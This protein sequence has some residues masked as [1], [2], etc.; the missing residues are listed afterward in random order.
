LLVRVLSRQRRLRYLP[1]NRF[2]PTTVVVG[3]REFASYSKPTVIQ[4]TAE[5][6]ALLRPDMY[7]GSIVE[8][9]V[10]VWL[11]DNGHFTRR[12]ASFCP[13]LIK[14]VDEILV[15][16]ADNKQRD[17]R[18]AEIRVEIDKSTGE[19]SV[20]NDGRGLQIER[21][22]EG[23]DFIPFLVFGCLRTSTNYDDE[24]KRTVGGRNGFG[25]KLANIYSTRFHVKTASSENGLVFEQTWYNNMSK[26]DEPKITP[27]TGTAE[28]YTEVRFTPDYARLKTSLTPDT[29]ALLRRRVYDLAATLKGV[30]ISL[31]GEEITVDGLREYAQLCS[32]G[33]E[34]GDQRSTPIFYDAPS[35]RWE[36]AMRVR[37][38]LDDEDGRSQD[39]VSFVNNCATTK[40]GK[41]VDHVWDRCLAVLRP[42]VE[43]SL[44]RKVRP[45]QIKRRVSLFIN[46]LIDNPTF[47]TQ[48][49][50]TLSTTA[51]KFGSEYTVNERALRN[52]A[53]QV[54]LDELIKEDDTKK[55][56][57]TRRAS[58]S[59]LFVSKLE[60]A[61][62][63]GGKSSGECSLLLTEGD[64]AK[65]LA[66]S[67]LQVIGRD[68]FGVYPLRGKLKNVS[69]MDRRQAVEVPEVA[70]LM[71]ILGLVPNADYST[72][73]QRAKLRYGRIIL[74]TDQDE[75]GSHIKGL[76]MNIFRCLWPSLLRAPFITALETPLIKARM[77][78]STVSF[79]SRLEYDE[80]AERTEDSEK[81]KIKYYKG[82]GTSTAEEAREY[83][84]DLESRLVHYVWT[85][86]EDEESLEV[87]FGG[88]K[89]GERK[90]WIEAGERVDRKEDNPESRNVP[91]A[92]FVNGE[93]R[94]FAIQDLKR[95]I[96]S[97]VDG[98]KP[99]QR[100][101]L[102]TCL[103]MGQGKQEKVA[104]LAARVAQSTSYHHG[105]NSLIK[106]I[107][108]MAQD[109]VGASNLPLLRGIGQF[110]TR[111][112]GGED[113]ASARYIYA[114]LSPFSRRLFPSADDP[115]LTSVVEEGVVAEPVWFCPILP[116]V[117]INGTEGIATGWSTTVHP[118]DP[119][120]LVDTVRRRIEGDSR[121]EWAAEELLP[122]YSGF[123]GSIDRVD[124]RRIRC[125]GRIEV[126]KRAKAARFMKVLIDELPV[127]VWTSNYKEK[128]LGQMVKDG[129]IRSIREAHTGESVRFEVELS[130]E[131]T[132]R[133]EK[134][135]ETL[136]K[137]FKLSSTFTTGNM[138]LFSP[139]GQLRTYARIGQILQ[140]HFDVRRELYGRRLEAGKNQAEERL[141]KCWNEH[142]FVS[143]FLEGR[144]EGASN[145]ERR[146]RAIAEGIREDVVDHL[147]NLPLSKLNR[148]ECA[149][150]EEKIHSVE[151][152]V[153][154]CKAQDWRSVWSR[155]LDEFEGE[156]TKEMKR[157]L[158]I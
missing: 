108:S 154:S 32:D 91:Y 97:V 156:W 147:L 113:A 149:K 3:R 33:R 16:A 4:V 122:Y 129:V 128:V 54:R 22:G 69:D 81:W 126:M 123:T 40:S 102:H 157:K 70:A 29:L 55:S 46:S 89:S 10:E 114:A 28:D 27:Q 49:K 88:D 64:S 1:A 109:F 94:T 83:F 5:Q 14:I 93:L 20:W 155:E 42:W 65:A 68:R 131:M 47:D 37:S 105:E 24:Q 134:K 13:G 106:A 11:I 86:G 140:E 35:E 158:R 9:E 23:G 107:V 67:G 51:S 26:H 18:M 116:L 152:E 62:L 84:K 30:R 135:P 6:H 143:S 80:W 104:Q 96:P 99:S 150:L 141:A 103:K 112:A 133:V 2:P 79:Y 137:L 117:L 139:S 52:W 78:S 12:L 76:V 17:E 145:E 15:N 43:K 148:Q 118:R 71:S 39:V 59:Q 34:E 100:K 57:P 74:L 136:T 132:K 58:V 153:L 25:A 56:T 125:E 115:L 45:G 21:M 85:G 75:D 36:V 98:L 73:E 77:G 127:G 90:R 138:V 60:D 53:E 48:L 72:P 82:L 119:L 121:E 61:A 120:A 63:A 41:H 124:E 19:I 146:S 87:A 110:G 101:I 111:H 92:N 130:S 38:R 31:N 95:S 7:I 50:E 144:I 66:V 44:Q 151:D 142:R 8:T